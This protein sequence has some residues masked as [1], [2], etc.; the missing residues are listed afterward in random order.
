MQFLYAF[1]KIIYQP[2]KI[3]SILYQVSL[4]LYKILPVSLEMGTVEHQYTELISS[5][6]RLESAET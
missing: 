6:V 4:T 5:I 2:H 3:Q 1:E